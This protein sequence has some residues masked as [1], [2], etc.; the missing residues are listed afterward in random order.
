MNANQVPPFGGFKCQYLWV[1]EKKRDKCL[2][3]SFLNNYIYNS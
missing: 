2:N 3:F 1:I